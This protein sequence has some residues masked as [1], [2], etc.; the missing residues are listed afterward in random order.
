ML[1]D[2]ATESGWSTICCRDADSAESAAYRRLVQLALIDLSS[3]S[4]GP[5]PRMRRLVERLTAQRDLLV[6]LCGRDADA[7]E[8]VWARQLGAWLYLP[9]VTAASDVAS[10]CGEALQLTA[11]ASRAARGGESSRIPSPRRRAT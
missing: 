10:I 7:I 8:E 1:S 9:K 5:P 3:G 4:A 11:S 2:A 6:A